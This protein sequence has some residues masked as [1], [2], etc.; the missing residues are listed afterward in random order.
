MWQ[1]TARRTRLYGVSSGCQR[2]GRVK[3]LLLLV[4]TEVSLSTERQPVVRRGVLLMICINEAGS[5][6]LHMFYED[7]QHLAK[8]YRSYFQLADTSDELSRYLEKFH[9]MWIGLCRG[10]SLFLAKPH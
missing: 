1:P 9:V 5:K 6:T 3:P 2:L 7:F 10:I 8:C 4:P